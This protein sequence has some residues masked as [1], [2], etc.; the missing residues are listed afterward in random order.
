[1]TEGLNTRLSRESGELQAAIEALIPEEI[2][3]VNARLDLI[4][5]A[6]DACEAQTYQAVQRLADMNAA[7]SS[8]SQSALD[9]TTALG[10]MDEIIGILTETRIGQ[11]EL[12]DTISARLVTMDER[13][14][15]INTHTYAIGSDVQTLTPQI[16]TWLPAALACMCDDDPPPPNSSWV[17]QY[18]AIES[19]SFEPTLD[20]QVGFTSANLLYMA[21]GSQTRYEIR[22]VAQ[23]PLSPDMLLIVRVFAIRDSVYVELVEDQRVYLSDDISRFTINTPVAGNDIW[24]W[25]LGAQRTDL[26]NNP[27]QN[28]MAAVEM[29]MLVL[30]DA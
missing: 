23:S 30:V 18:Q 28:I 15:N 27:E 20:P 1:M 4:K 3:H 5:L 25:S 26:G 21:A 19:F 7:L 17:A 13:L 8:I 6:V 11:F 24:F 14:Y 10:R 2:G 16:Q 9:L 22:H 12:L 29:N